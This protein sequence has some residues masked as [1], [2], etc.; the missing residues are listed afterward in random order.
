MVERRP[1]KERSQNCPSCGVY[2]NAATPMDDERRAP[3]PGDFSACA[4]CGEWL[5]YSEDFSLHIVTDEDAKELGGDQIEI[6]KLFTKA[7]HKA[8]NMI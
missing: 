4:Y 7:I 3:I 8:R 2:L 6:L 1:L 5:R